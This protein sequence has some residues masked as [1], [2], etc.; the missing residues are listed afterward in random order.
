MPV[1]SYILPSRSSRSFVYTVHLH[2][3]FIPVLAFVIAYMLIFLPATLEDLE[4]LE[5]F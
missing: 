2:L 4:T 1:A 5:L 3:T